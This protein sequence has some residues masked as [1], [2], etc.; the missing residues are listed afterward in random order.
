MTWTYG[1]SQIIAILI[2]TV[3]GKCGILENKE[4]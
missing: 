3:I 2:C 4:E 1:R